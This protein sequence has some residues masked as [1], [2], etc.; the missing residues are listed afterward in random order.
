MGLIVCRLK[1]LPPEIEERAHRRAVEI[2]SANTHERREV[3]RTPIGTRGGPRRIAVVIKKRWPKTG[4]DLT[5]SFMDN[6]PKALRSRILSHM[7]A[8]SPS[9]GRLSSA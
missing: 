9:W 1:N 6:P 8:F 5:V 7:N 4:V 2:N 3:P